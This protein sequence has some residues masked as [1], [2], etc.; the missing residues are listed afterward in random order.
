LSK[1]KESKKGTEVQGE[2]LLQL[3]LIKGVTVLAQARAG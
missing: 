2:R 1:K 3:L